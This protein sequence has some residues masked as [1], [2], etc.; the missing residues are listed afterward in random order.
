MLD[1]PQYCVIDGCDGYGERAHIIT[2]ATLPKHL[3]D[4]PYYYI[5]LCRKHHSES[6]NTGI[7]TFC[8]K[9]GLEAELHEARE[10]YAR[11]N[12]NKDD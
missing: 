2:R 3:W 10:I 4:S 11:Y 1:V 5:H 12:A 9:Y 8:A 7:S 6:H